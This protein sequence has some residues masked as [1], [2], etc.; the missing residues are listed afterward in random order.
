MSSSNQNGCCRMTAIESIEFMKSTG[1]RVILAPTPWNNSMYYFSD[2][3]TIVQVSLKDT[4]LGSAKV[5]DEMT[6]EKFVSIHGDLKLKE[7]S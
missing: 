5:V 2:H 4:S 6:P 3:N 1:K 7:A